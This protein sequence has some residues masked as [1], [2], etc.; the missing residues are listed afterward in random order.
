LEGKK[1]KKK[2]PNGNQN[3]TRQPKLK[4]CKIELIGLQ[5]SWK[6][7]TGSC[8]LTKWHQE[9]ELRGMHVLVVILYT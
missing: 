9:T 6:S 5:G 8:C 4:V 3:E 1:K 7:A 2:T